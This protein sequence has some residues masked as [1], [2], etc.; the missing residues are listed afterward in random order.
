MYVYVPA[1]LPHSLSHSLRSPQRVERRQTDRQRAR[2]RLYGPPFSPVQS[3]PSPHSLPVICS[4]LALL[5]AFRFL[6]GHGRVLLCTAVLTLAGWRG[7]RLWASRVETPSI[8]ESECTTD[9]QTYIQTHI[10]TYSTRVRPS[11]YA[12]EMNGCVNGIFLGATLNP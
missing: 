4:F 6:C 2:E 5:A 7:T 1:C 3:V 12:R 11:P 9:L 8:A 10:H